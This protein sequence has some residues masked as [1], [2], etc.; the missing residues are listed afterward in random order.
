MMKR[1]ALAVLAASAA[2]AG[3][4]AQNRDY[5]RI[6]DGRIVYAPA[7][8]YPDPA[9]PSPERYAAEGWLRVAADPPAPPQGQVVA[10]RRYEIR[11]G[12]IVAVYAYAPPPPQPHRYSKRKFDLAL[13]RRGLFAQFDAWAQS[14][15]AVAGSGLTVARLLASSTYMQD[16]DTE[17]ETV[18]TLSEDRFGKAVIAAVLAESEDEEW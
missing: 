12:R 14:V 15:E 5:G 11:E 16:G 17:F 8:L 2:F 7:A 18:K 4:A 13:A 1:I 6:E 3:T 10:S 9:A